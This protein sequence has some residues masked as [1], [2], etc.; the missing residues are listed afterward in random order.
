MI[1]GCFSLNHFV[2]TI[3]FSLFVKYINILVFLISNL[4]S[5]KGVINIFLFCLY[6]K[7]LKK[8]FFW[9]MTSHILR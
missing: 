8:H 1:T 7:K 5:K 4:F 2:S 3:I 6:N 9:I